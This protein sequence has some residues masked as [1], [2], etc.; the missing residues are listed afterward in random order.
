MPLVP[1]TIS[2]VGTGFAQV[3]LSLASDRADGL[4]NDRAARLATD[5]DDIHQEVLLVLYTPLGADIHRPD[6]GCDWWQWIDSP[7][8]YARPHIVRA[9]VSAIE[10]WVIRIELVRV[11]LT[12]RD[13]NNYASKDLLVEW[14][15][16]DGM[17][18]QIFSSNVRLDDLLASLGVI[19]Q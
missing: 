7:I 13:D 14:K 12:Q 3:A 2:D 9:V 16:A 15:F 10:R 17:A 19:T 5:V 6:F 1:S 8:N 18:E 11:V 4:L